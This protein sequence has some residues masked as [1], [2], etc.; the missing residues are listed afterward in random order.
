MRKL[1]LLALLPTLA[2]GQVL[3]EGK[4]E[5]TVSTSGTSAVSGALS[6]GWKFVQ[7]N[8]LTHY[9][10]GSDTTATA[11]TTGHDDSG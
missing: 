4:A 8:A 11:T 10:L 5:A 9:R 3:V 6:L 7:C 2:F 1:L